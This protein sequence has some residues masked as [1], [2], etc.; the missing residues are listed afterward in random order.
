MQEIARHIFLEVQGIKTHLVRIGEGS[1]KLIF[2]HGWGGSTQSFWKLSLDLFPRLKNT[3][4]ILVD[5]PGF[6]L[7]HPP[8]KPWDT[9]DY[10]D[11]VKDLLQE[12]KVPCAHFYVHS[13]GGRILVR[14][15]IKHPHVA[16]KIIFTGAAG[17]KWPL[18]T[19]QKISMGL[20]KVF[21]KSQKIF[22]KKLQK[23]VIEKVFGARDWASVDPKLKPTLKK[24]LS[25]SDF[26]TELEHIQQP[27]LLLWGEN[28]S[29]TPLKSGR[30]YDAHLKNS[31]LVVMKD[32]KHGIHY[33]HEKEIIVEV[34]KFLK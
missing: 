33:T 25:E 17:I 24:V 8:K 5:Y 18:S 20:S 19:R 11:W 23:L 28:D 22:P 3:E 30:V 27:A 7:T 12:I 2:L 6:G 34:V 1:Q 32:G 16:N 26:R 9:F 10:A 15:L 31:R 4:I 14:L 21:P 13:F 29:I